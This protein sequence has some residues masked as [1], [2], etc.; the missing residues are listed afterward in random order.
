MP[1][2]PD[3]DYLSRQEI[4]DLRS[5]AKASKFLNDELSTNFKYPGLKMGRNF[6]SDDSWLHK[7]LSKL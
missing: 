3:D 7:K 2:Y 6:V 1:K 5:E 4:D